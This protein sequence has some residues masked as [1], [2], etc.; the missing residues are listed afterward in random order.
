MIYQTKKL[1]ANKKVIWYDNGVQVL[2][3]YTTPVAAYLPQGD[4]SGYVRTET[5]YSKTTSR[6]INSWLEGVNTENV[7]QSVLD[8]LIKD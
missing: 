3:S 8:N 2:I 6:H 5:Y 1:G 4:G 7:A